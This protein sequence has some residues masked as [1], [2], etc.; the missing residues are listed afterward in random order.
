MKF[1]SCAMQFLCTHVCNECIL[2]VSFQAGPK[3][4]QSIV[5]RKRKVCQLQALSDLSNGRVC[6][7]L[8][9][10]DGLLANERSLSFTL[11][12]DGVVVFKSTKYSIWPVL[13][14]INELPFS[15][16]YINT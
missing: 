16:R 6:K 1:S 12:T 15:E 4:Y 11:N 9:S 5:E 10:K 2:F 13:L 14:M 3:F 7:A 8:A